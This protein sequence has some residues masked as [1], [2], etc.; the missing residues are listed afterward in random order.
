ME[1]H[2]YFKAADE[3]LYESLTDV[4]SFVKNIYLNKGKIDDLTQY[5]VAFF[6]VNEYRGAGEENPGDE[7]IIRKELYQLKKGTGSY[8]IIDLGHLVPGE[9]AEDTADRI[10][11]VN[12]I[13][14]E[15]NV[16]PLVIGGSHDLTIGQYGAYIQLEKLVN[17]LNIDECL[18]IDEKGIPA[19][20][21]VQK[22]M[23]MEPNYLF[24]FSH[25]AYQ[26]Y[27]NSQQAIH[28]MEKLQ[29]DLIRLGIVRQRLAEM[30]PVIRDADMISFDLAAIAR[31]Q[32]QATSSLSPFGLSGE[33]ACQI[34]WYAGMNEKLSSAGFYGYIPEKDDNERSTAQITAT[35]IWYF[36][37]GFYNRTDTRQFGSQDYIKYTVSFEGLTE[38]VDE[39]T[40]YKSKKSDKWWMEVPFSLERLRYSRNSIVP[41]SYADYETATKGEVPDRWISTVNK[42]GD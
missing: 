5:H 29:F 42:M 3:S 40:F 15:N 34:C 16:L 23:L 1:I 18:D 13:L 35:M 27:L 21:H 30:E 8:K 14:I 36:I 24:H 19:R 17:I 37:E 12:A 28:T 38:E 33:E 9:T 6:T 10:R 22:M 25:I 2:F 32:A 4:N 26:S 7:D 11:A 31:Y 20:S 39:I 41:C